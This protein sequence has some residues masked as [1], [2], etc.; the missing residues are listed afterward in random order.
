MDKREIEEKDE[1][2]ERIAEEVYENFPVSPVA[3]FLFIMVGVI[4]LIVIIAIASSITII[5]L[6]LLI[7]YTMGIIDVAY[8]LW[9]FILRIRVTDAVV[10]VLEQIIRIDYKE[11]EKEEESAET[12]D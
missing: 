7:A 2:I 5:N 10:H 12:D 9:I 1:L 4:S 3:G 11:I 6:L 8:G